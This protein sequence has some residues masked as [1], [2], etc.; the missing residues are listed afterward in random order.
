M[1]M[2]HGIKILIVKYMLFMTSIENI[3]KI[4]EKNTKFTNN[5]KLG[6]SQKNNI[7]FWEFTSKSPIQ[8]GIASIMKKQLSN[9]RRMSRC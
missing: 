7:F 9:D 5:C 8:Y 3:V 2:S 4:N 6:V 1:I